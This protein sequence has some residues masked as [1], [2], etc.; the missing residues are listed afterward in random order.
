MA[1]NE[2]LPFAVAGGANVVS[3]SDYSSLPGRLSGYVSGIAISSQLNKTWR[4]SAFVA[5]M[6]G[7]FTADYSEQDVLDDGDVATFEANFLAA[8]KAQAIV[9]FDTLVITTALVRTIYGVGADF[10]DIN[11]AM[12]WLSSYRIAETG[13]VTF[14]LAGAASGTA[15]QYTSSDQQYIYHPNLNRVSF[16][17][18]AML[19]PVP[20][21][22]DFTVTGPSVGQRATDRAAHLV[23]MRSRF[24]TELNFTGGAGIVVL[25][26]LGA[27][28]RILVTGDRTTGAGVKNGTLMSCASGAP[29]FSGGVA[30]SHAGNIGLHM[31][32]A[33]GAVNNTLISS[34]CVGPNIKMDLGRLDFSDQIVSLSSD[35]DGI[36]INGGGSLVASSSTNT[37]HSRGNANNGVNANPS[38]A[39][40]FGSAAGQFVMNGLSGLFSSFGGHI[41][42]PG[43]VCTFNNFYGIS[44]NSGTISS[45]NST[46]TNNGQYGFY[47][48]SGRITTTGSNLATNGTGAGVSV[49][50]AFTNATGATGLTGLSPVAG[51][52]GNNNSM[53]IT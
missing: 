52:N 43:A 6:I 28:S 15:T 38:G 49:N 44:T 46:L 42:A 34:G 2:L 53:N 12:A 40:V 19:G 16:V 4:Q 5:A 17:G 36:T 48:I 22:S 37:A 41:T 9:A 39:A 18:A 7:E 31:R 32:S 14:N 45:S 35:N 1:T 33:I 11:A 13:S 10:V 47:N 24:A 3:Q 23:V 29:N 25:G 51:V 30:F 8:I 26:L 27:W 21:N 50:G 20:V